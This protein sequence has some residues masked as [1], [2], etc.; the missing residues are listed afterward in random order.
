MLTVADLINE[1]RR[2]NPGDKVAVE[3][4]EQ[5]VNEFRHIG[6]FSADFPILRVDM[7]NSPPYSVK[8]VLALP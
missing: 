8:I 6:D 3:M 4:M 2:F 7:H 5:D 1:L